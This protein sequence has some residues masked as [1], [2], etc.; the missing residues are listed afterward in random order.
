MLSSEF[1][2]LSRHARDAEGQGRPICI[3]E[4]KLASKGNDGH[5]G[6]GSN[7][8]DHDIVGAAAGDRELACGTF[9]AT[10][11]SIMPSTPVEEYFQK[12]QPFDC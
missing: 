10:V 1:F 3:F 5:A 4:A 12:N 9:G 7:Q 6:P 11:G 8:G 2:W